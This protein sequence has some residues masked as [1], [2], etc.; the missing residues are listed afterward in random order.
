MRTIIRQNAEHFALPDFRNKGTI[1][2]AVLAVN[3]LVAVAALIRASSWEG[4]FSEWMDMVATVEPH[5]L[6]VLLWLYLAGTWLVR[7]PYRRGIAAVAVLTVIVGIAVDAL[8]ERAESM[9]LGPLLRRQTLSLLVVFGLLFYFNLRAKALS[10]AFTEARLQAL[11]AR[12]RPH[13]LFN[14]LNAVLSL[15]RSEPKQAE[16]ALEDMAELFRV[17][18]RDNRGLA[19]LEDEINLCRQYLALEKL[20]LGDR[21]HI[22]WQLQGAPT[23]ALVPPLVLQPLMENAIYHGIEPSSEGGTVSI[24][25]FEKEGDVH[26]ILRNPFRPDGGK[27]RAGN[28]LALA[29]LRERLSLHFDAEASLAAE[30]VDN[31]YEARIR[32]PYRRAKPPPNTRGPDTASIFGPLSNV[33][34]RA[35]PAAQ[36]AAAPQAKAAPAGGSASH[37]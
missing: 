27:H 9:Q 8:F 32:I 2:R 6:F 19:P 18:M 28:K 10:P 31:I 30:V 13:F 5:L 3:A 20:R 35:E 11:Q 23:D 34:P 24:R 25:I 14:S 7:W 37:G 4:W 22:D 36:S 1:L 33:P 16:T 15:I 29:N 21:L 17:L 26:A 12:I